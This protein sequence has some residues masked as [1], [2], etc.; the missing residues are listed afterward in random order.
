MQYQAEPWDALPEVMV[1]AIGGMSLRMAK[2]GAWMR[3]HWVLLDEMLSCWRVP[4]KCAIGA[5]PRLAQW[6]GL[7]LGVCH[8]WGTTVGLEGPMV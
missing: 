2:T 1:W 3:D 6:Q 4:V 5:C 7:K 8:Y